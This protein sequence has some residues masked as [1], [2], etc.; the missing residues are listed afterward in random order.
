MCVVEQIN[1]LQLVELRIDFSLINLSANLL[2]YKYRLGQTV[3]D[4][5]CV[6]LLA[7][8]MNTRSSISLLS[9]LPHFFGFS[10]AVLL[11]NCALFHHSRDFS[12][13][14]KLQLK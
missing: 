4:H 6:G 5:Q 12:R 9:F 7:K 13:F 8:L 2:K 3:I 14:S 10:C 1:E 11:A